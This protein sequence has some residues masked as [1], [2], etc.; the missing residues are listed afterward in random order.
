MGVS[1]HLYYF[2]KIHKNVKIWTY[3]IMLFKHSSQL[4][5]GK[6]GEIVQYHYCFHICCCKQ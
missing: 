4:D 5:A 1:L 2:H 6:R 3:Y